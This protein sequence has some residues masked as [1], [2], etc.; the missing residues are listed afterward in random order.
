MNLYFEM[1][2]YPVF[3]MDKAAEYYNSIESARSAVKRLI[4]R[5][6]VVKIRKNLYTCVSGESGEPIADRFQVGSALSETACISHHTAA[7][8]YGITD[9]VYYDVYVTSDTRFNSFDFEG[10]T[11]VC[12]KPKINV[13]ICEPEYSGGIKITDLERTIIDSINDMDRIS[14]LEEVISMIDMAGPLDQKKLL[15]YMKAYNCRFLYQKAGYLLWNRREKL[16]LDSDFFEKCK[17]ETGKSRR[18]LSRDITRGKYLEEWG[19]IVADDDA[20]IKNGE[21]GQ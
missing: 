8:Y 2:K 18:Y 3:T 11:Y 13:G 7:E 20:W 15:Q 6:M 1:L 9:Q 16:G 4:K 17:A 10:Y 19:L 5:G 14:G 12:I 21:E